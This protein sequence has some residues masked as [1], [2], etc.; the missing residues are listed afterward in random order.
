MKSHTTREMERFVAREDVGACEILPTEARSLLMPL[1]LANR[2][3]FSLCVRERIFKISAFQ[4]LFRIAAPKNFVPW[5][6]ETRPKVLFSSFHPCMLKVIHY[7]FLYPLLFIH[8][9]ISI[10]CVFVYLNG[11]V[12]LY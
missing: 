4:L 8:Y 1:A 3:R 2:A 9:P 5:K 6:E 10:L 11:S 12:C 7:L